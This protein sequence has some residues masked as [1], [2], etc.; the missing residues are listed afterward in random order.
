MISVSTR[1]ID[2]HNK[3]KASQNYTMRFYLKINPFPQNH[4]KETKTNK[5]RKKDQKDMKRDQ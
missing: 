4:R 2:L 1:A 3:I 5:H